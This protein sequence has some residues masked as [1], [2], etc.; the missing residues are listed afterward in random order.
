MQAS[1]IV[2]GLCSRLSDGPSMSSLLLAA[3]MSIAIE[4]LFQH[5]QVGFED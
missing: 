2:R 3:R 4:A 1:E 5:V